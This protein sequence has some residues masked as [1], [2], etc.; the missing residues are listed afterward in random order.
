MSHGA[1][2]RGYVRIPQ[3]MFDALDRLAELLDESYDY[4]MSFDPR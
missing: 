1:V 3:H 4:V 2:M